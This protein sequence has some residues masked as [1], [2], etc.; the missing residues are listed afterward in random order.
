MTTSI[1]ITNAAVVMLWNS[2]TL[3]VASML[4]FRRGQP[5]VSRTFQIHASFGCFHHRLH[6]YIQLLL[7]ISAFLV[8]TFQFGVRR[9]SIIVARSTFNDLTYSNILVA[10]SNCLRRSSRIRHQFINRVINRFRYV[11]RT[12][13][14]TCRSSHS[15]LHC[16]AIAIAIPGYVLDVLSID[17]LM[18]V[19][20]IF[21]V[22]AHQQYRL[23]IISV[24]SSTIDRSP[25]VSH[26]RTS[27][28]V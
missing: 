16:S 18:V 12:Y 10:S 22:H 7:Q 14:T 9:L 26:V 6:R 19:I 21:F 5:L 15:P 8:C 23:V 27:R 11:P 20:S 1:K 4:R 3:P 24:N 13:L 28:A 17:L 25:N 2:I